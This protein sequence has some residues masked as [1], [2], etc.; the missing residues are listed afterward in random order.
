MVNL[1]IKAD[2][3]KCQ[4]STH[5]TTAVVASTS[6]AEQPSDQLSSIK[7]TQSIDFLFLVP[8]PQNGR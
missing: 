8:F 4:I 6:H 1:S 5:L 3:T 7:L 2:L